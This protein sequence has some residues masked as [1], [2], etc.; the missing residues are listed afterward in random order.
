MTPNLF[1]IIAAPAIGGLAYEVLYASES[2][3]Y[4]LVFVSF[5]M[6]ILMARIFSVWLRVGFGP[7]WWAYIFPLSS[8]CIAAGNYLVQC[9]S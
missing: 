3:Y 1:W 4:F 7:M 5:V 9:Y 6:V 8:V 2:F